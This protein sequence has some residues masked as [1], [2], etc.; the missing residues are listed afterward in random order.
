MAWIRLKVVGREH[1]LLLAAARGLAH[2]RRGVPFAEG[3]G[4]AL[5]AQPLLQQRELRGF[6]GAVDAF[7][8]NQL[9]AVAVGSESGGGH[10][11]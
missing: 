6:A 9:S 11:R 2:Q 4:V 10:T 3:D 7:D 1:L 8:D 5:R